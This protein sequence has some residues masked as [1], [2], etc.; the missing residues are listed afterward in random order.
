MSKSNPRPTLTTIVENNNEEEAWCV[1]GDNSVMS[2]YNLRFFKVKNEIK[3]FWDHLH[4]VSTNMAFISGNVKDI[5]CMYEPHYS[6]EGEQW[7]LTA[8]AP[9]VNDKTTFYQIIP[10]SAHGNITRHDDMSSMSSYPWRP[11]IKPS[12]I[13]TV[14]TVIQNFTIFMII[15][16]T[17]TWMFAFSGAVTN[18][19]TV[20]F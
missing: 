16:S 17:L 14:N 19:E 5:L 1:S 8:T 15:Y 18:E 7:P 2:E 12:D 13:L 6:Y 10:L 20:L 11:H 4:S 9:D 3:D